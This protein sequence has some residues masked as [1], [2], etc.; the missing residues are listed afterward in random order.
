MVSSVLPKHP[1][2]FQ[3]NFASSTARKSPS[4]ES[5]P[6]PFR[7]EHLNSVD[8]YEITI[9]EIQQHYKLGTFTAA[10]YVQYCLER[11][12]LVSVPIDISP[13]I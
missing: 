8:L 9:P 6:P 7:L 11:I 1:S 10:E 3:S 2:Y 4:Q 5:I 13:I 12:R